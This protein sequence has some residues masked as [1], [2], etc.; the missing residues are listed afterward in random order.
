MPPSAAASMPESS[1]STQSPPPIAANT[2]R[3]FRSAFATNV[4]PVSS[5]SSPP[6]A[7]TSQPGSTRASSTALCAFPDASTIR[8][9][10]TPP[11]APGLLAA[12]RLDAPGGQLEQPV[13]RGP[14]ERR[15]L[16]R[17]LHLD[18]LARALHDDVH[19]HLGAPLLR[20]GQVE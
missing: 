20:V 8:R 19:V 3:A 6:N 18:Q 12:D 15:A 2:C 5:G 16:G 1:A 11:A 14:P 13:E 7:C 9:P 4:S 17:R 10:L